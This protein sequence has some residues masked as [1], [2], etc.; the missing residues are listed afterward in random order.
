MRELYKTYLLAQGLNVVA[1]RNR[2]EG[3][4]RACETPR[5]SV[6]TSA[7]RNRTVSHGE[8]PI[9]VAPCRCTRDGLQ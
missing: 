8:H 7:V 9:V 6:V 5:V 2:M 3:F 1:A 4:T